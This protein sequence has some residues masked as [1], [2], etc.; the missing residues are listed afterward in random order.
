MHIPELQ[1]IVLD[2]D[3]NFLGTLNPDYVDIVE[4]NEFKTLRKADISHP[5]YDK[6]EGDLNQYLDLLVH[7]NKIWQNLNRDNKSILYVINSE[8]VVNH[9]ENNITIECTEAAVEL[10][11]LPPIVF[12]AY[13]FYYDDFEDGKVTG[14]SL[15]YLN[16]SVPAGI[17]HSFYQEEMEEEE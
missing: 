2:G 1:L 8:K 3:E 10:S 9:V 16:M 11:Y 12:K 4:Y 7:G 14:R 15:P 6:V 13:D 17:T 5:I